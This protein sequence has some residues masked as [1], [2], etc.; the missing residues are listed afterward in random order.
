MSN[1]TKKVRN[2]CVHL[3]NEFSSR[4]DNGEEESSQSEAE[5]QK[6]QRVRKSR[7]ARANSSSSRRPSNENVNNSR[8]KY[9]P[10]K[11]SDTKKQ[12]NNSSAKRP[13]S[14]TNISRPRSN[15]LTTPQGSSKVISTSD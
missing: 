14:A 4:T 7:K 8:G 1:V 9:A 15:T 5:Q 6:L 10:E 13:S 3:V 2:H 11:Y 12:E